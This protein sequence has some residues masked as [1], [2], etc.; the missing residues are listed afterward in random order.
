M[1]GYGCGNGML[2][3]MAIKLVAAVDHR[4]IFLDPDPDT[5]K[6]WKERER[7][8]NLPRSS[9]ADYDKTLI[10]TGGGGF[11]CSQKSIH[12]TPE[13]QTALG[14]YQDE[15]DPTALASSILQPPVPLL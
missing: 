3:S 11:P 13:V 7:L 14:L 4:H 10:S 6:S 15:T 1:A 9:W 5:A 8:F 2:L 12:L